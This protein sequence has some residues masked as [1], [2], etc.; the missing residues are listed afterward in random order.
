M[1]ANAKMNISSIY[2]TVLE[3]VTHLPS[4]FTSIDSRLFWGYLLAAALIG[5]ACFLCD[6]SA[7][8]R[9]LIGA[10][11]FVIPVEVYS[12]PSFWFDVKLII[13]V[14]MVQPI[15]WLLGGFTVSALGSATRDAVQTFLGGPFWRID[16]DTSVKIAF[17]VL[18]FLVDDFARFLSHYL[19]H[20][21]GF[22]WQ[23]HRIHHSAEHLNP[24]TTFRFHP[25]D[26][27]IEECFVICLVGLSI[28]LFSALIDGKF[29]DYYMVMWLW[30][31]ARGF[32]I[33]GG[34]LRHTHIWWSWGNCLS[35]VLIS[36]AQHQVHHSLAPQHHDKN[37]GLSLSVWDWMF[38]TLYVPRRREKLKFGL[39]DGIADRS[40]TV[41]LAMPF[42]RI[43]RS[44]YGRV[45]A[46]R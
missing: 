19:H 11:R 43:L 42:A 5:S 4:M 13:F 12:H 7:E 9:S 14:A 28:G 21:V 22:L 38:G 17:G 26:S 37:F 1:V 45:A 3:R 31:Y 34:N 41:A 32:N 25:L 6:R 2:A 20:R 16:H 44:I 46:L 39:D 35:H 18:L 30:L 24:L 33:I 23:F 27:L 40:L 29:F 10:L 36:P 8:S 15:A